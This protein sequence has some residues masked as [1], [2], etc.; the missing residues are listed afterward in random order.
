MKER[1]GTWDRHVRAFIGPPRG[2]VSRSGTR[3]R[4]SRGTPPCQRQKCRNAPRGSWRKSGRARRRRRLMRRL[5]HRNG[6]D[7]GRSRHTTTAKTACRAGMFGLETWRVGQG[8]QLQEPKRAALIMCSGWQRPAA[9]QTS[10]W[11][12]WWWRG[13]RGC[14]QIAHQLSALVR[15]DC[16]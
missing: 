1:Q 4:S 16:S 14:R 12:Q 2:P 6:Q 5:M 8:R 3:E 15:W 13:W 7:C 10:L 11:L 9:H